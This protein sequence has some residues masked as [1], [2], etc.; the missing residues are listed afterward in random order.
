[1]DTVNSLK[2]LQGD[3]QKRIARQKKR[4]GRERAKSLT[5]KT[6][7]FALA[8]AIT[9]LLGLEGDVVDATVA[10][11]L[12]LVFGAAIVL[13]NAWEAFF[14]HRGLWIMRTTTLARLDALAVDIDFYLAG[15]EAGKVSD[16][17]AER[18]AQRYREVGQA[19]LSQWL[20]LHDDG[21]G[22]DQQGLTPQ[23]ETG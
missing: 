21:G 4:L 15:H 1:M 12:A 18:F 22:G 23:V 14:H 5:F 10:K 11:N 7:A 16:A 9:V 6:L 3:L 17:D 8:A 20:R 2:Y 13:V 19:G